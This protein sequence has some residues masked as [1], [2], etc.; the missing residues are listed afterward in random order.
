MVIKPIRDQ[1]L[2]R[3]D[4][5]EEKSPGGL[6]LVS[7]EPEAKNSG[8]VIAVGESEVIKVKPGDHVVFEKG[9]GRRFEI[10]VTRNNEAGVEWTEQEKYILVAYYDVLA[11]LYE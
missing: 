11:V 7:T 6:I 1:V 3:V 5:Q 9:M 4:S 10:P 8:F 2:I